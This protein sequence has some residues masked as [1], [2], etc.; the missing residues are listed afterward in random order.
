VI[1]VD[2]RIVAPRNYW[3]ALRSIV[4]N[5]GL[6]IGEL[7]LFADSAKD[8]HAFNAAAYAGLS[9]PI[10]GTCLQPAERAD[11]GRRN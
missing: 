1:L 7:N 8:G 3:E 5:D 6:A 2:S 9:S 10:Y 4:Q 11:F